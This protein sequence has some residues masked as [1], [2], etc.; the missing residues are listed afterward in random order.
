MSY[1]YYRNLNSKCNRKGVLRGNKN[2]GMCQIWINT[3]S[4]E[5]EVTIKI[6][7]KTNVNVL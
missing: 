5:P 4:P 3:G 1:G 2:H 6:C 7:N